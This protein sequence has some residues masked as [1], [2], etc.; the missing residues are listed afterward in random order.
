MLHPSLPPLMKTLVVVMTN[1]LQKL[2][3]DYGLSTEVMAAS[4]RTVD[5]VAA[6]L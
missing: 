3:R 1:V 4:L 5:Q 6:L 2:F